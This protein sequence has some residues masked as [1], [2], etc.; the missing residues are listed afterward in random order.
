MNRL[1]KCE[2]YEDLSYRPP[3]PSVNTNLCIQ[4]ALWCQ[5]E[6]SDSSSDDQ[7]AKD[8]QSQNDTYTSER[9]NICAPNATTMWLSRTP[10]PYQTEEEQLGL[11][12]WLEITPNV[13]RN[14]LAFT[15][16]TMI[17]PTLS[18]SCE[19][20]RQAQTAV[21]LIFDSLRKKDSR[22]VSDCIEKRA[23]S[24]V[25]KSIHLTLNGIFPPE[26][27]IVISTLFWIFELFTGHWQSAV[28]HL[29]G[30]YKMAKDPTIVCSTEPRIPQFVQTMV[31]DYPEAINP[32]AMLD[33]SAQQQHEQ[34]RTRKFLAKEIMERALDDIVTLQDQ[35]RGATPIAYQVQANKILRS[36]VKDFSYTIEHWPI[37]T[38]G[39]EPED[40]DKDFVKIEQ[41]IVDHSPFIPILRRFDDFLKSG[42]E[43][44]LAQFAV[45]IRQ[46]LYYFIWL[47]TCDELKH[48]QEIFH[49]WAV[50][51]A[52]V[53]PSK[54]QLPV[55]AVATQRLSGPD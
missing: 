5:L 21:G 20:V 51:E 40:Q 27:S 41:A 10:S 13:G 1:I 23:I 53:Q 39:P 9:Q 29:A 52:N 33:A 14:E 47:A 6:T 42:G 28:Q 24:Y 17:I 7:Q 36:R 11:R 54:R 25:N 30:G 50:R 26:V 37:T 2:G 16:W 31:N 48:R 19:P 15:Y 38:M 46:A 34:F 22:E 43:L 45:Q 12:S 44:H 8:D 3:K 4:R 55:E 18:W 32:V 49:L 35:L